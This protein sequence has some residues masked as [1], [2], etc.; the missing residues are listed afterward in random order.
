MAIFAAVVEQGA[1]R[2]AARE[3]GLAPSRISQAVSD[4]EAEL[5]VTLLYRSTRRLSLTNEGEN[6]LDAIS[7]LSDEPSGD[8]RVTAPAF[9]VQT[10]LLAWIAGFAKT[11]PKVELSLSFS[12]RVSSLIDN[13]FDVSIRAGGP[14]A[15]DHTSLKITEIKRILVASPDYCAPRPVPEHPSDLEDWDWIRFQMRVDRTD[16]TL[17]EGETVSVVGKSHVT[18]DAATALFDLSVQG[19][20]LT[21]LPENLARLGI[22]RGE[23]VHVLPQ[24]SLRPL[25][26]YAIW[27]DSSHRSN[28]AQSF[29]R[30][31]AQAADVEGH[32]ED[33][34]D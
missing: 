12:D 3:L 17:S 18:V 13:G 34:G 23:L 7:A 21:E 19:V 32:L 24:W 15:D 16:L 20:G 31:L 28:L 9:V 5:G 11:F 33:A 29:I 2:S 10:D 6:G 22:S 8:L 1:F 27:A 30:Y 4:L 25:G 26:I 14:R